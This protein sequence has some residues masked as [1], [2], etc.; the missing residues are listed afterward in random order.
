MPRLEDVLFT[1]EGLWLMLSDPR[2]G[3]NRLDGSLRGFIRS[4]WAFAYCLPPI[5]LSWAV[6]RRDYLAAAPKGTGTGI[7]FFAKLAVLEVSVWILPLIAIGAIMAQSSH[8]NRSFT[9]LVT[10]NWLN[11]PI[12]WVM[13]ICSIIALLSSQK[14]LGFLLIYLAFSLVV[15]TMQFFILNALLEK[16]KLLVFTLLLTSFVISLYVGWR[17]QGLLGLA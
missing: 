14:D 15:I 2:A 4:F 9:V 13:S 12:H 6:Y 16:A 17:M 5:L 3:T 1:L 8:L 11:V 7:D 10:F